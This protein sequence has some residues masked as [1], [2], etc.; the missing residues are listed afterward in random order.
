MLLVVLLHVRIFVYAPLAPATNGVEIWTQLA[1]FF[2]AFR[3]PLLFIVSGLSHRT[4]A[5]RVKRSAHV[6]RGFSLFWLF[7]VWL[8]VYAVLSIVVILPG[9]PFHVITP[10]QLPRAGLGAR[11]DAVVHLRARGL[12][13][14]LASSSGA[15]A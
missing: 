14:S 10:F 8:T 9:I 15:A 4:H 1:E 13:C 12:R 5:R 6:L 3:L 2:G 7:L 11:L